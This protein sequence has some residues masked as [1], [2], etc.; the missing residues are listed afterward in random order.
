MLLKLKPKVPMLKRIVAVDKMTADAA[1]LLNE[2]ADSMGIVFQELVD[3]K[4][5]YIPF[6][7]T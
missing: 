1:K 3:C 7:V 2:W 6:I 4:D 5:L